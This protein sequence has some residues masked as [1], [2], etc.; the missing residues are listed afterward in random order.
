M[1][2]RGLALGLVASVFVA[3]CGGGLL[4]KIEDYLIKAALKNL[5]KMIFHTSGS[6]SSAFRSAL[7]DQYKYGGQNADEAAATFGSSQQ[8]ADYENEVTDGASPL[9]DGADGQLARS[10]V[11]GGDTLVA[12]ANVRNGLLAGALGRTDAAQIVTGERQWQGTYEFGFKQ[13]GNEAYC[14]LIRPVVLSERKVE[15]TASGRASIDDYT[16]PSVV[17]YDVGGVG[18]TDEQLT[19]KPGASVSVSGLR[20]AGTSSD[21]FYE[22]LSPDVTAAF[23]CAGLNQVKLQPNRNGTWSGTLA[24]P[25]AAGGYPVVI[26]VS[27][28]SN[29]G[30]E[31]R[32]YTLSVPCVV[33]K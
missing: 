18:S 20:V 21:A 26:V 30:A 31:T 16:M 9:P 25:S 5:V 11:K 3:G 27:Y 17:G 13:K 1:L 14:S 7:S 12:D 28:G 24:A 32:K 15:V 33:A 19:V 4:K 6:Y 10:T 23:N 29:D 22:G 2:K 8:D